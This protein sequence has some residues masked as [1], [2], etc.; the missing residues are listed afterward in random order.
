MVPP[1][2][3]ANV[4]ATLE[5]LRDANV[6]TWMLTGDKLETARV[7]AQNASLVPRGKGFHTVSVRSAAE[8][9]HQL[10]GYPQAGARY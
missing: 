8:A 3:Q 1:L 10:N 9:R 2:L 6:R 7:I 5:M 4:R